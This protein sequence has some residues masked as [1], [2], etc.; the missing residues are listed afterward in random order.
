[1]IADFRQRSIVFRLENEQLVCDAPRG[2]MTPEL[3]EQVQRNKE[4]IIDYLK[5]KNDQDAPKVRRDTIPKVSRDSDIPLSFS[6]ESLWFFEQLNPGTSAYNIP[7]RIRIAASVDSDILQRSLDEIARRHEALRTCFRIVRGAPTQVIMPPSA[8]SLAVV[9]LSAEAPALQSARA[10]LW[11]ATEAAKPFQLD[12]DLLLRATLLRLSA[13]KYLLLL[14]VHHIVTDA[15]SVDLILN[16]LFLIYRA[17]SNGEPSQLP[18]PTIQYADFAVWQRNQ[19]NDG[20]IERQLTYWRRQMAGAPP[21]LE[22]PVDWP[23]RAGRP[24]KGSI[25]TTMVS[26]ELSARLKLLG[27][28]EGASLFMV[29][30]AAFQVL[31]YRCS[32]ESD[33]VVGAPISGRKLLELEPIVGLFV[34]T[35]PLRIDLSGN[36]SFRSVL[37]R[38]RE[39]VLEAHQNQDIPFETL[40]KE[41]RPPRELGRNPLFQ[42][43]FSFRSRIGE[44]ALADVSNEVISNESAK[45]DLSLSVEE[46]TDGMKAEL[47]YCSDLFRLDRVTDVLERLS[48]LLASVAD[49]PER[50][51]DNLALIDAEDLR[52]SFADANRT[53]VEY[54]LHR[55]VDELILEGAKL[56][57]EKEA[58]KFGQSTLT[59]RQLGERVEE[60]AVHLRALG[61]RPDDV[62]GLCVERSLELVIGLLAI[63]K[64]GAAFVPLDPHYPSDRLAYMVSDAR[65]VAILV[66]NRTEHTIPASP[67][68]RINLDDLPRSGRESNR[69]SEQESQRRSTDL[70]Y[71]IYTSGSTGAP[72][73]VEVSHKSLMNFLF[74]MRQQFGV[75]PNDALLAV[76]TISFDIA[77]LELLLPL[78]C[79]ARVVVAGRDQ[80]GDAAEL[81]M[82]L[83]EQKISLMQATP[84]T[85]RLLLAA[86][87]AG[88]A[89]LTALCGGEAWTEDLAEALLARCRSV[90][91]MYGPTETTIWSAVRRIRSGDRVLIGGPIANTQFY[92]LGANRE[93]EAADIPGELY[94]GGFGVSRGYRGRPDLTEDRFIADPF[95]RNEQDRLYR[96][97]DRVRRLPNGDIEFLGRQDGQVKIRGFRIELDEIAA[98]LRSHVGITDA[99][100]V[101][102]GS[103]PTEKFLVA[104]CTGAGGPPP[105]DDELRAFSRSKLPSYMTPALFEFVGQFPV[106]PSGKIDRRALE[107]RALSSGTARKSSIPPRT[108]TERVIAETWAKFLRITQIG[109]SDDFFDLGAHSLMVVEVIH[110]LNTS[111]GFRIGVPEVFENPTV[112]KLA[113]IVEM[114]R[115]GDRRGPAVI[116]LRPGS[117]D[118]PIYFIY[119][120]PAELALARSIGGDHPVFGIEVP[121]PLEWKEAVEQNQT[122]RF[123][124]MDEIAGLFVEELRNHLGSGACVIAGYSFAGLLAFEVTRRF[125]SGGGR[126]DAVVIIDKWLPYPAIWAVAWTNLK[127]CWTENWMDGG[128]GTFARRLV[129]SGWIL[130]W[131]LERFAKR[132]G[133]SLWLRP[134]EL[135]SFLDQKGIPLRWSLVDRLYQEIERNYQLEPLDCRGIVIRPEFL[136]RHNAVKAPDEYLGWKS[137]FERGVKALSVPGDHFSMV[138]EHG[139]TLAQLIGLAARS[140]EDGGTNSHKS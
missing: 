116:Q 117:M 42:V 97:G 107:S 15:S 75:T 120:G 131:V 44:G 98:V 72:K 24:S 135:T 82:I 20:M 3:I 77:M 12:H 51:I 93:L 26:K 48:K 11:C 130:W 110:E 84:T 87:W 57:P 76:T 94:I 43:L 70:A 124:K 122:A 23:R 102:R 123:P 112:E 92:V 6:Q 79:G 64:S 34:N 21:T 52:R 99:V 114:Q 25:A 39:I 38:V 91:N 128:T 109:I 126:V 30:L 73:G 27:Q 10:D 35:L 136:E 4:A 17:F 18:E 105:D 65:P 119:A 22:L 13:E 16:E 37:S 106:T 60:V 88:S 139:H 68:Q 29:L 137:L 14:I 90:W 138:Q 104:Y 103:E 32:G 62:V 129:R 78:L 89:N 81:I 100:V 67:A 118:V 66:Q 95:G 19:V 50:G 83:R 132:M 31:L 40:V 28:E 69:K 85:W 101:V 55:S 49:E 56:Y 63:L 2:A 59:Y 86:Q 111:F 54:D 36:P 1:M 58:V 108:N 113:A 5:Q 71:V 80:V 140:H 7:L 33:V 134:N 53:D 121:W 61:V 125:L 46:F 133:S 115:R 74:A 47:E 45:F 9:D 127:E 8:V 96:T 41:L